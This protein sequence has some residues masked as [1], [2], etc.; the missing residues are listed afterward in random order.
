MQWKKF[1]KTREGYGQFVSGVGICVNILLSGVKL[2]IGMMSGA[3]SIVADAF[4]NLSDAATSAVMLAGFKF[5]AKPADEEHP[6]GHGRAEYLAGLF[7]AAAMILVGG[8]LLWVSV[9]KIIYPEEMDAGLFTL[10]AMI[11]SIVAKLFLGLFYRRASRKINSAA[12]NAEAID[13]FTDCLAT[14]A[15]AISIVLWLKF[16]INIDGG[17]GVF[18]SA[19]ILRGGFSSLKEI[20][21]PLLGDR[22]NQELSDGIKK[23]VTDA[24]EVLGVHDLIIH[25]YGAKRF[26]VSLHVEMPATLSLLDAHEIIDKLERR[27]Q[28]TFQIS[29]TLHIDPVVIGDKAFDEH[30]QLAE[31][32]LADIDTRLTL[33]DFRV[34]PYKTG[35]KLIFDVLVPQIFTR[36]DRE[37]RKE[38]QRRLIELHSDDRA[39]IHFDHQYC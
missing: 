28:S 14:S 8:K 36:S 12:L 3:V 35:R 24:P 11:V 33:H 17:A 4:N 23:I 10:S 32:I 39:I 19:F 29:A 7:I 25:S 21:N 16:N 38:F 2:A 31:K 1:F 13:S 26:F 20:L 6:F 30:R 18:V 9:E 15:V 34:V 22:P 5:A 37:L 27:L